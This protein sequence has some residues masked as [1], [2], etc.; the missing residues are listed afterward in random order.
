MSEIK[1]VT[2]Y[3]DG[4]CIGNPGPGGYA[5]VLLYEGVRRE[6]SGGY[7][8]TTNNRMEIMA[9][10]KGLE[11]LKE[12][13]RVTLFSDSQ[14]LVN[15]MNNGWVYRWQ[16]NGWKRNKREY[17]Q[18]IDLWQRLL[19]LCKKHQVE[20]KWTRGHVGNPEN[21]RC[22]YLANQAANQPDLPEEPVQEFKPQ[23][24]MF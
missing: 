4:A 19:K 1:N 21:E 23:Q 15:S 10:I 17:A 14:Y 5:A 11:A 22:D 13:C 6:I 12:K 16:A 3:T 18:N 2:I 9:T 20:F 8:N 7:K 24:K